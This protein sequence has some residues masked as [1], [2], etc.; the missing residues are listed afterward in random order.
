MAGN[1]PKQVL[2][3]VGSP[4]KGGNTEILIDEVLKGAREAGARVEKIMLTDFEIG[5]CR[6]C[7]ACRKDGECVQKEDMAGLFEK[8]KASAVWVIGTPVYWWGPSAQLK[9]F[10]DRWFSN[11]AGGREKEMFEGRRVVLAVPMGDT[12]PRTGRHVVGMFEDAM[13]YVKG[14]LFATVMAPGAYD[15]GDVRANAEVIAAARKAGADAV[16]G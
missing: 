1:N 11:A 3:I 7:Y 15:K 16:M 10:V 9:A 8:M 14:E 2:G 13:A 6:A 12:N 4:R 5:P